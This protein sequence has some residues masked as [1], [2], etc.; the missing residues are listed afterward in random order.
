MFFWGSEFFPK[1]LFFFL[2]LLHQESI[3]FPLCSPLFF[4]C[5]HTLGDRII[6]DSHNLHLPEINWQNLIRSHN[7]VVHKHTDPTYRI[8]IRFDS[9]SSNH[10]RRRRSRRGSIILQRSS[11][12]SS[13]RCDYRRR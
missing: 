3:E 4:S 5:N 13:A 2:L 1:P 12:S 9:R 10:T 11:R 7:H 6:T 8:A